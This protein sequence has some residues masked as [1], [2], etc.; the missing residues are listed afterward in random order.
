MHLGTSPLIPGR[1]D[2]PVVYISKVYTK[3]GDRGDTMLA[4]GDTVGKDAPRVAAYGDVDEL[5]AVLGVLRVE[6][7]RVEPAAQRE[8]L[9]ALDAQLG[10]IQQELFDLGAELA[11][12]GAT[13]GKAPLRVEEADVTRLE[14]ELDAWN[15]DL[16]PLRSF[17]LPGG[18]PLGAYAH[19]ARTVCRRAERTVVALTRVEPVRAEAV[20]YLNRL[21]DYFFVVARAV[22]HAFAVPE[23]LWDTHRRS[24]TP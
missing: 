3:F 18:G 23:V 20:R 22:A 15:A 16:P 17:I 11:T 9:T 14:Q 2:S 1:S 10:R 4:S 5:N 12:P 13:E 8:L 21:S 7:A 19:L 24:S 6:L